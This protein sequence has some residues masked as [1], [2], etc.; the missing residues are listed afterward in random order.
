MVI[1]LVELVY[2]ELIGFV[3]CICVSYFVC[4]NKIRFIENMVDKCEFYIKED[5]F[6]FGCGELFGVKGL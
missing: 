6:V 1:M 2:F 5:F 4:F 3:Q